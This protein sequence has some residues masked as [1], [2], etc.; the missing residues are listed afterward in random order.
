MEVNVGDEVVVYGKRMKRAVVTEV[1]PDRRD[2]TK[3]GVVEVEYDN[4]FLFGKTREI[5]DECYI[6]SVKPREQKR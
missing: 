6:K 3:A 1:W 2:G 4:V 5:I